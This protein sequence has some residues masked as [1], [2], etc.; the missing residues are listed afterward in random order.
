MIV[1]ILFSFILIALG[2]I[3]FNWA[4]GG[5]FG[6]AESLPTKESGESVLHP[7]KLDS[8]LVGIGLTAFGI[9]YIFKSGLFEYNLPL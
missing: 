3:H 2:L 1:S 6:F 5:Q 4:I 9:F 7:K 8:A